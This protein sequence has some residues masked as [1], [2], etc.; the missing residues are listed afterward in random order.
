[1]NTRQRRVL[2]TLA[3][4]AIIWGLWLFADGTRPYLRS[5]ESVLVE[6]PRGTG[7]RAMAR[8][9]EE[10]GA[11][12]SRVTF[13]WLR[14]LWPGGVLQAGEYSFDRPASTFEVLRKLGRGETAYIALVIPEGYNR[15]EIADTAAARGLSGRQEFLQASE[16]V[17]LIADIA[18]QAK[19]L[20]GYLFPDTYHFPLHA[21][22]EQ[23]L[24][25][26]VARF[27]QVYS[28]LK[29]PGA[30]LSLHEIV[31][32]ASLVEKETAWS[33]ERPL[34]AAVFYNRL[35]KGMALQ[36]DP[37]VIYAA[38]LENRYDG[39]IRQSHLSSA[40]PY[41]TYVHPGLPPGP[42]ANP[43][44]ASLLAAMH[45]VSS[46]YLYF[47]ADAEGGS[48]TFSRTLAEHNL[49]VRQYRKSQNP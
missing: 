14:M 11:I 29:P 23:L 38:L 3:A 26:M 35:R 6:I 49:A 46:D 43:G 13:L 8:K 31:T 4:A 47:V 34:V 33:E 42:I 17:R 27:R 1:M 7:T 37:T 25:S 45:P 21:R 40:S 32:L 48:H 30:N 41:N 36:C 5:K 12:R 22:P 9:L 10:A 24:R 15:F 19:T 44:K 18:P 39:A 16:D 28:S 2:F 20:E